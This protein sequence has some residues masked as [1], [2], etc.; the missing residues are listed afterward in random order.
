MGM[1]YACVLVPPLGRYIHLTFKT[2]CA[3]GE[4]TTTEEEY[5]EGKKHYGEVDGL[6]GPST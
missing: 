5:L 4:V 3:L 2:N 6:S 1:I